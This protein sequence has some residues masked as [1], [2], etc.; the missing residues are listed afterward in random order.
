MKKMIYPLLCMALFSSMALVAA[1]SAPQTS[2]QAAREKN[3]PPDLVDQ[4][5]ATDVYAI[6]LDDSEEEEDVEEARLEKMQ[7]E[8][9]AK[10]SA[11]A[12]TQTTTKK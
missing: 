7:K 4:I 2:S 8:L 12:K 1:P 5:D 6:P 9:Q 3:V 11:P 10:S